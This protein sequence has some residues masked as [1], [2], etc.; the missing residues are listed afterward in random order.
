MSARRRFTPGTLFVF[1]RGDRSFLVLERQSRTS[2]HYE[3][4]G[5]GDGTWYIAKHIVPSSDV[6]LALYIDGDV[7]VQP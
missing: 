7:R 1:W 6:S 3:L 4:V 2:L 5:R